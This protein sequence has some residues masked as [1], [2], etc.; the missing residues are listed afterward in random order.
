MLSV[1][2]VLYFP[3]VRVRYGPRDV[4]ICHRRVY[5]ESITQA[6]HFLPFISNRSATFSYI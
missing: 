2:P 4:K 1:K 3:R 6:L 5:A